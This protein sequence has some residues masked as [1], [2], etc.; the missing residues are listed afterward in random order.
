[1]LPVDDVTTRGQCVDALL[2]KLLK[3]D[4]GANVMFVMV[5][6]IMVR[7]LLLTEL[8]EASECR[9]CGCCGI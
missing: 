2:I 9:S 7:A 4:V 5:L 3:Q 1:M 6:A 8:A